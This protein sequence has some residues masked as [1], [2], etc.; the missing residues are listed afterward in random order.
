M[1]E[2]VIGFAAEMDAFPS[3]FEEMGVADCLCCLLERGSCR[4][5]CEGRDINA[6]DMKAISYLPSL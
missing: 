5:S 2:L 6:Y 1:V 4:Y 3:G